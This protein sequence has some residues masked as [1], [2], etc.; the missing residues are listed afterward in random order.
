[1]AKKQFSENSRKTLQIKTNISE[2]IQL[3]IKT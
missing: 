2:N 3:Q 1:M